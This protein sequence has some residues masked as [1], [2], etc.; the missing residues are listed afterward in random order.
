MDADMSIYMRECCCQKY[1]VLYEEFSLTT[2]IFYK[3]YTAVGHKLFKRWM[4][5]KMSSFS[6]F[7]DLVSYT[8]SIPDPHARVE[9]SLSPLYYWAKT[10][11]RLFAVETRDF[12]LHWKAA[13]TTVSQQ[14][15]YSSLIIGLGLENGIQLYNIPYEAVTS[16]FSFFFASM[17]PQNQL[18]RRRVLYWSGKRRVL[19]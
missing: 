13:I 1:L 19:M 4:F 9:H 8:S 7:K 5:L 2:L 11:F 16:H 14:F 6:P 10:H 12:S 17:N 18:E 3:Y 15:Q